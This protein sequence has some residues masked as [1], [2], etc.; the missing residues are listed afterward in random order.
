MFGVD[1]LNKH[2]GDD[3][4]RVVHVNEW[5]YFLKRDRERS[6]SF[7]QETRMRGETICEEILVL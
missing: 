3:A 6:G 7:V 1:Y 5:E 4:V 2:P